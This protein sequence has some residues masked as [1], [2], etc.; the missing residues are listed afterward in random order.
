MSFISLLC[1]SVGRQYFSVVWRYLFAHSALLNLWSAMIFVSTKVS[2]TRSEEDAPV[3][4]AAAPLRSV[5]PVRVSTG[6]WSHSLALRN[7]EGAQAREE[8]AAPPPTSQTRGAERDG[9]GCGE[10]QCVPLLS[11]GP[12]PLGQAGGLHT[13]VTPVWP[14]LVAAAAVAASALERGRRQS[15]GPGASLFVTY[16]G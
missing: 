7:G 3:Q 2:T 12:N 11:L 1:L 6:R 10:Q 8:C 16:K 9:A 13:N 5:N 4:A 14:P 15:P